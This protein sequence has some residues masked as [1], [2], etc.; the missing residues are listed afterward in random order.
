LFSWNFHQSLKLKPLHSAMVQVSAALFT[1]FIVYIIHS[2]LLCDVSKYSVLKNKYFTDSIVK[3]KIIAT[4][5]NISLFLK[6][7]DFRGILFS[8]RG[9]IVVLLISALFYL[10]ISDIFY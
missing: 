1:F 5:R 8:M 9:F 4:Y 10:I 7:G 3:L 2:L 6:S